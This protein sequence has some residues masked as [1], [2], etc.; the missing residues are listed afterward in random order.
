M[1]AVTGSDFTRPVAPGVTGA[2]EALSAAAEPARQRLEDSP[3]L[4]IKVA[5]PMF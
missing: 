1:K 4:D 5:S 2:V 3:V